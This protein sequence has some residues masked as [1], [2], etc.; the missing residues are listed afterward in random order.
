MGFSRKQFF[1]GLAVGAVSLPFA[2]R[3]I[4]GKSEAQ[5]SKT[6]I[7]KGKTYEWK[8]VTTWPP[9]FPLLGDACQMLADTIRTMSG[10][11]MNISVYGGGELV[12]ALECFDAV[13][14]GAVEMGHGA[15]YYWAGKLP[16]AQFFATVPFGMNGQQANAWIIDG[17]GWELWKALYADFNLVPF[18]AGNTGVQMGGWFNREIN[19]LADLQDLKMRMP[20]I[21]GKVLERAGG[22]PVLLAGGEI[23]TGLERGV[24]DATE[25]IGPFHDYKIGFYQIA[26]YYYTPG[27]HEPGTVLETII[28]KKAYEALPEDLQAIIKTANLM[29]NH[30]VQL[31]FEAKNSEY[32]DI[33]KK[34]YQVDVRRFPKDLLDELRKI[35]NEVLNEMASASPEAQKVYT[36]YQKFQTSASKWA[37]VSEKAYYDDLVLS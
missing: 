18:P 7:I 21:G 33:L 16:A 17:G 9:N 15:A 32:L 27:W 5:Q 12:P 1:K 23:Y 8:M 26:K 28:N 25:W 34:D 22:T 6:N 3:G 13:R 19:S 36:S 4:L 11:R 24:I 20:G 30:W 29:V 2:L 31:A 37:A 35:T 10:G 14:T